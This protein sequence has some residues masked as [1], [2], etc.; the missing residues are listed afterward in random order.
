MAIPASVGAVAFDDGAEP[1]DEAIVGSEDRGH[2]VRG[3]L[4]EAGCSRKWRMRKFREGRAA[5]NAVLQWEATSES[6]GTQGRRRCCG[7]THEWIDASAL[8]KS[9][10]SAMKRDL[11]RR[12]KQ[13]NSL[14]WLHGGGCRT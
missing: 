12:R 7:H 10:D 4:S 5:A 2:V 3:L 14:M 11:L 1:F 13:Q 6:P 9:I 8:Q